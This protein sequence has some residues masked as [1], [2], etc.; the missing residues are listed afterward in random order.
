MKTF[1]GFGNLIR[2]LFGKAL[3][4]WCKTVVPVQLDCIQILPSSVKVVF[5]ERMYVCSF[6]CH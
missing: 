3:T 5:F 2:S 4:G 6:L 1:V